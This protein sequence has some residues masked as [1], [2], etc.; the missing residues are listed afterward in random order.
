[1]TVFGPYP[2]KVVDIHDGD[3]IFFDIDLGFDHMIVA[4]GWDG[5][6]R[7]SCRVYGINAPELKTKAGKDALAFAQ[8]LIKIGDICKVSSYGW[9]KYGGRFDGQVILPD[10]TN[11][12]Q[13]MLNSGHAVPLVIKTKGEAQ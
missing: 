12:G 8:T 1:M 4:R 10:G 5:T 7:L 3:T 13:T 6:D 11:F 2:A 9:D